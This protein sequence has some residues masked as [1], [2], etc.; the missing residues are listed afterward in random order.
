MLLFLKPRTYRLLKPSS[1]S[2]QFINSNRDEGDRLE[3][4]L[5]K[6]RGER[7][8]IHAQVEKD[9]KQ[10]GNADGGQVG[11]AASGLLAERV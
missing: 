9:K 11:R 10:V 7:I 1:L 2:H 8:D 5:A 3:L 4:K 6:E